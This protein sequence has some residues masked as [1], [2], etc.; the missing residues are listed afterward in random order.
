MSPRCS[1]R[2]SLVGGA[3]LSPWISTD[4]VPSGSRENLW[5]TSRVIVRAAWA[6]IHDIAIWV[7]VPYPGS[8]LFN[9]LRSEGRIQEMN[10]DYFNRLAA[11]ADVT[12]TY[13]YCRA[14]STKQLLGAR[15]GGTFL[16]YGVAWL[17][18]PWRPFRILLNSIS[19]HLESRSELAVRGFFKRLLKGWT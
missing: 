16:F 7:F 4:K 1:T 9:Q 18:R 14:L 2:N 8:E 3:S 10:D 15:I 19:G 13:S 5:E 11:Y 17:L 6:G 12:Q